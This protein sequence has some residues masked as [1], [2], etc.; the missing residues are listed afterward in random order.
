MVRSLRRRRAAHEEPVHRITDAR[1]S[2]ADDQHA[3]FVKYTVSMSVRMVFIV[4]ALIVDGPLLWVCIAG[5]VVLP[6]VAVVIA[7]ASREQAQPAPEAWGMARPALGP[8]GSDR[9]E[10]EDGQR[11]LGDRS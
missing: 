8:A 1:R 6:Y 2:A 9:P 4:L 7:N 10:P 11:D 3:R 5:A